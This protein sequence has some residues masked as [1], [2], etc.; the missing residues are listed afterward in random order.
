MF[1]KFPPIAVIGHQRQKKFAL[2][3]LSPQ[4]MLSR[5][6]LMTSQSLAYCYVTTARYGSLG[7]SLNKVCL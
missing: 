2:W 7:P 3:N 4:K 5:F 6:S 1:V